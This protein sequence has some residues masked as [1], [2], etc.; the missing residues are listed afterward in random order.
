[1][2]KRKGVYCVNEKCYDLSIYFNYTY[3]PGDWMQ[4][5]NDRVDVYKVELNDEDMPGET[6]A[7]LEEIDVNKISI[8]RYN[9]SARTSYCVWGE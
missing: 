2:N 9:P 6:E 7:F 8:R 5:P 3:D 1:M 4:P